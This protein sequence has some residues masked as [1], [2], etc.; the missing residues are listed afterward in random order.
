[1]VKN[2]LSCP[3]CDYKTSASMRADLN[4]YQ[5]MR[6]KHDSSE[7]EIREAL[8]DFYS[9]QEEVARERFKCPR[10]GG[11]SFYLKLK[12]TITAEIKDMKVLNWRINNVFYTTLTCKDCESEDIKDASFFYDFDELP[13]S[14]KS[15]I[16]NLYARKMIS[17][18]E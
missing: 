2:I 3:H 18:V 1:M 17:I 4:L 9:A 5:H 7:R 11:R 14:I 8:K 16:F 10:C 13:M 6:Y 15:G 12:C